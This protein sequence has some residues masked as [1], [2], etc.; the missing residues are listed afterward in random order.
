MSGFTYRAFISY[1]H[2]DAPWA[3]W[4]HRRLERY[5]VPSRLVG[6]QTPS[7]V[8]PRRIGRC[9]RDQVELS[10]SSH[11]GETLQQALRDSQALI[12]VCSPR[13]AASHWVNEEIRYFRSLGRGDHVYALIVDGEPNAGDAGRDCFPPALLRGD[14]GSVH[15]PLAADARASKDGKT[16]SFLKLV[17]GLLGVGFDELRQRESRRRNRLMAATVAV[18]LG[19]TAIT[20]GLAIAAYHAR[21]EAA[22]R[23]RQA[24]DLV[25]FLVN[26]LYDKLQ[27]SGKLDVLDVTVGKVMDHFGNADPRTLDNIAL[28]ARAKALSHIAEI[29]YTRGQPDEGDAAIH[30][31]L[32]NARELKRR[33][34]SGKRGDD[35]LIL[36]LTSAV[37]WLQ[38]GGK[39]DE[40]QPMLVE[41]SDLAR[42]RHEADPGNAD[43]ISELA[44]LDDFLAYQRAHAVP[45]DLAASARHWRECIDLL[46]PIL[47]TGHT[48]V[49]DYLHCQAQLPSAY[50]AS[51]EVPKALEVMRDIV[52]EAPAYISESPP[53]FVVL[54]N[55]VAALISTTR[56]FVRSG[57]LD[58]ADAA[59]RQ[60]LALGERLVSQEPGNEAW[61][62][63]LA[64][65]FEADLE[66]KIKREAWTEAEPSAEKALLLYQQLEKSEIGH[67]QYRLYVLRLREQRA[68]LAIHQPQ[69]GR[70]AALAELAEGFKVVLLD[71][72]NPR[73][74]RG[75]AEGRLRQWLYADDD[76]ELRREAEA[77]VHRLLEEIGGSLDASTRDALDAE[78][79]YLQGN[80][81]KGEQLYSKLREQD[82]ANL[83][84]L[85]DFRA[86]S[87]LRAPKGACAGH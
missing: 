85:D 86:F 39:F 12:I 61:Q 34:D 49:E 28:D 24:E 80:V 79:A 7:G 27:G 82:Y 51:G 66:L 1:S 68:E 8:V 76:A 11:L 87:C 57:N 53:N 75:A 2:I 33:A 17:A 84:A 71:G 54:Q 32:A 35:L 67:P 69:R 30:E 81:T 52:R 37:G 73:V 77:A 10:A 40:V 64:N 58:E 59:S 31:A 55:L 56:L 22:E 6:R 78:I 5:R 36:V 9:F 23:E 62:L 65:A 19:V 44:S 41:A 72:E 4:L 29:R 45:N 18:S 70:K 83:S 74:L 13:S 50:F 46:K 14:D 15:E 3:S 38:Q 20:T 42:Q 47:N 63:V 25:T 43:R 26:D 16:D 48:R 21:N 60:T